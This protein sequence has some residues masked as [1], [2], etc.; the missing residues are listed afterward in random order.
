MEMVQ[1]MKN[2]AI[3]RSNAYPFPFKLVQSAA[4][5]VCNNCLFYGARLFYEINFRLIHWTKSEMC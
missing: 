4:T 2:E 5:F 3:S 1:L